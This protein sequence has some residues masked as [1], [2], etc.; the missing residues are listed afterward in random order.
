MGTKIQYRLPLRAPFL[1]SQNS[2]PLG[3]RE[4]RTATQTQTFT[5]IV[6]FFGVRGFPASVVAISVVKYFSEKGNSVRSRSRTEFF[7][8]LSN[9]SEAVRILFSASLRPGVFALIFSEN[10]SSVR[11]RSRARSRAR[12]RFLHKVAILKRFKSCARFSLIEFP[13]SV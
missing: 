9:S 1:S 3:K 4:H 13:K 7:K 2:Q 5:I 6:F 11:S 8:V 12:T 10:E